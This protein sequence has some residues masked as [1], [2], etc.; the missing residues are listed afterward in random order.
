MPGEGVEGQSK[1][2]EEML[3][4]SRTVNEDVRL[5]FVIFKRSGYLLELG[6]QSDAVPAST[7]EFFP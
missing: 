3:T 6:A 5:A 2:T 4:I 7:H 1:D